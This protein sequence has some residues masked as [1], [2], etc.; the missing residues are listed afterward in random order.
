MEKVTPNNVLKNKQENDQNEN[1]D[2]NL[3]KYSR[4]KITTFTEENNPLGND[5]SN[6][7][8]FRIIFILNNCDALSIIKEFNDFFDI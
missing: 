8:K 1:V 5:C 2:Q 3:K 4:K 6:V 7:L